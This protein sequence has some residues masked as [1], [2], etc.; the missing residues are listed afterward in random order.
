MHYDEFFKN[1]ISTV[2]EISE[3]EAIRNALFYAVGDDRSI[4]GRTNDMTAWLYL[5]LTKLLH[6]IQHE[7][8]KG[9]QTTAKSILDECKNIASF[10]STVDLK[11]A[12]VV[13]NRFI[14]NNH[15]IQA[16]LKEQYTLKEQANNG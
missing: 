1:E 13:I 8:I 3:K 14:E 11:G 7:E 2:M 16:A 12:D 15:N 4:L 6:S 5:S 10:E 9:V